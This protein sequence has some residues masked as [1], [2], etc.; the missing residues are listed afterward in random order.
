MSVIEMPIKVVP[1]ERRRDDHAARQQNTSRRP[2]SQARGCLV[3]GRNRSS[4]I[5][6]LAHEELR[7]LQE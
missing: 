6:F 3:Y 7:G 5:V 1:L 4:A 2:E